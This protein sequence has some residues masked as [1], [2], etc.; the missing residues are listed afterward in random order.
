[1]DNNTVKVLLDYDWVPPC[2]T[3]AHT[4]TGAEVDHLAT[5]GLSCKKSE[6][7]HYCHVAINE[8][9]HRALTKA[10]ITLRQEPSGHDRTDGKQPDGM[11]LI[12]WKNGKPLGLWVTSCP[13]T[14]A[15][16][17]CCHANNSARAVADKAELRKPAKYTSLGAGYSFTSLAIETL[18]PLGTGCWPF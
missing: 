10:C 13:D 4:N 15:R 12:P 18:G 8:I 5:H 9:I 7:H 2:V 14:L 6:G 3:H 17:Y 16:S 1:M 11:T